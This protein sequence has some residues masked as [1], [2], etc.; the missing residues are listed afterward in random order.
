MVGLGYLPGDENPLTSLAQ[1]ISGDGSVVTGEGPSAAFHSEAFRWTATDGLVGLGCL[2]SDN[3]SGG[4]G[5]SS[6]GSTIVGYSW[7]VS[8]TGT[9]YQAIRWTTGTGMV[10]LGFLPGG[11]SSIAFGASADGS[12]IVGLSNN[13]TA[14][15]ALRWT[16]DAGM[17]GLGVLPGGTGSEAYAV[18]A[19][20]STIVGGSTK[21]FRWTA[22]TGMVELDT[23]PGNSSASA[24]SADGSTIVGSLGS[25]GFIWDS[26]HGERVLSAVLTGLGLNIKGWTNL[27]A[28]GVSADG[29]TIA[30][31]GTNP[32]GQQ[33][34]WIA[35]VPEPTTGLLVMAGVLGLAVARRTRVVPVA[36]LPDG[37]AHRR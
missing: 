14:D 34:A 8:Q 20:G 27:D 28:V 6:D 11:V 5:I 22:G 21:A 35:T 7:K 13:G 31:Y 26:T 10:G 32:S 1:A 16:S 2:P 9:G 24:V 33:E 36:S 23:L 37:H 3:Q 29:L 25:D 15:Q 4:Y 30:G 17:M 19:D 12:I 18:S